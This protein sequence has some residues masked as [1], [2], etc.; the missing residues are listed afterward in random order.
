MIN[1]T[2]IVNL[3]DKELKPEA[4]SLI[5]KLP[6][7]PIK[8]EYGNGVKVPLYKKDDVVKALKAR[9]SRKGSVA[10]LVKIQILERINNV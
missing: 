7:L 5:S 10:T 1:R 4:Y 3:V 2:E 8:Y 9:N 6:L